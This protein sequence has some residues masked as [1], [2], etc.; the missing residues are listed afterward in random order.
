[1]SRWLGFALLIAVATAAAPAMAGHGMMMGTVDIKQAGPLTFGPQGLLFVAD[2]A[3]AAIFAIETKD[4][5][6]AP[7]SA[8]LSVE[9][10]DAKVAALLPGASIIAC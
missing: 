10:I 4:T 5:A 3:G 8:K 2:P 7:V 1:M 6:K 9:G